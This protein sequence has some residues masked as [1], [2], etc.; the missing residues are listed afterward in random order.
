VE[1][2]GQIRVE[3]KMDWGTGHFSIMAFR[4]LDPGMSPSDHPRA[5]TALE[6]ELLPYVVNELGRL[7]LDRDGILSDLMART[8]EL[9]RSVETL[10]GTL[11]REWSRISADRK[12]V[13]AAYSVELTEVLPE[14]FAPVSFQKD[15][16]ES[17]GWMP[18]PDDGWTGIAIYVPENLPVRG[19]GINAGIKMALFARILNYDLEVLSDP[20]NG[21]RI[22]YSYRTVEERDLS[23]PVIGRRPFQV[24]ARELYGEYACDIILGRED[25]DRLLAS[26]SGRKA[27]ND[28]RIVILLDTYPK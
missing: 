22:P 21:N 11:K 10:A 6:S 17:L 27:L 26:E 2:F 9:R 24:M 16:E 8:P 4:S 3:S 1:L 20:A 28:G 23:D 7:A 15:P 14:I 5:L 18:V 25:T 19:T 12:S 13:E